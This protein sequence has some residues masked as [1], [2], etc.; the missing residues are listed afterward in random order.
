LGEKRD[1][2]VKLGTIARVGVSPELNPRFSGTS[3]DGLLL[4]KANLSL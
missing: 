2:V 4:L 3:F 1:L